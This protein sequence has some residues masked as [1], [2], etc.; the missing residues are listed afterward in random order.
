ML[1]LSDAVPIRFETFS[2][3]AS[4]TVLLYQCCAHDAAAAASAHNL[5][6]S[7]SQA[8]VDGSLLVNVPDQRT[9]SHPSGLRLPTVISNRGNSV[10]VMRRARRC[11]DS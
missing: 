7:T 11:R 10:S 3:T 1:H 6:V 9:A 4:G 2:D 8:P 5:F